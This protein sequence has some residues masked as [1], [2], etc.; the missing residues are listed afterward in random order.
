M[1]VPG[2][3]NVHGAGLLGTAIPLINFNENLA[4]SSHSNDTA[5]VLPGMSWYSRT[6][7]SFSLM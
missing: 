5:V 2:Y 4:W 3:L 1:T 6:T 7:E